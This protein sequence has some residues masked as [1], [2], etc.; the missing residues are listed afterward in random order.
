[1]LRTSQKAD[2][3]RRNNTQSRSMREANDT[4]NQNNPKITASPHTNIPKGNK[5]SVSPMTLFLL[6][7]SIKPTIQK[8]RP[9]SPYTAIDSSTH[10]FILYIITNYLFF[11]ERITYLLFFLGKE[12]CG[13]TCFSILYYSIIDIVTLLFCLKS[14]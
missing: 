5:N 14:V 10:Q 3:K 13:E 1:M 6:L 11:S 4:K 9:I 8:K 12:Q 7:H 2:K